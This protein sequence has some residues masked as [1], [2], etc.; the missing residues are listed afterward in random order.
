[1]ASYDSFEYLWPPRP[2]NAIPVGMLSMYEKLGFVAQTKFNGTCSF[3][4]ISPDK[5]IIA[6]NRHNE[7]HKAWHPD[8]SK[9]L[10]FL[11]LL[12]NGWYVFVAELLHNKVTGGP[13]N[14]NYVFDILV[15]NGEYLVGTSQQERNQLL[16][17]L[18]PIAS[19]NNEKA[20][21][22]DYLWI[23]KNQVGNFKEI[24]RL[25]TGNVASEG[26]V[27]KN[28]N[29]KLAFCSRATSNNEWQ[30]KC[31]KATKNYNE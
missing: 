22:D 19:A 5:E 1:M 10:P 18:F 8:R 16:Y 23:A 26:L 21:V 14:T 6:V 17:S 30:V 20:I 12:G 4:A 9:M 3:I 27:L 25:T 31:R 29:A 28:P 7:N 13:R 15:N 24:F 11:N 2:A